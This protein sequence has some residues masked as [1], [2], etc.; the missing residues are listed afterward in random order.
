LL[1]VAQL[2]ARSAAS[3]QQLKF[4]I[5]DANLRL[6]FFLASLSPATINEIKADI[7]FVT[8]CAGVKAG[9]DNN[10]KK[11]VPKISA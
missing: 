9:T 6:V 4:E 2:K 1:N 7:L 3:R 10:N 8:F 11:A 5:F